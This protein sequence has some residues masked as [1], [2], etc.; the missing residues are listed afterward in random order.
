MQQ[1]WLR[2][3]F[4][5]RYGVERVIVARPVPP[6]FDVPAR[7]VRP[8]PVFVYPTLPRVFK[9]VELIGEAVR[10][11]EVSNRWRGSVLVTISGDENAY[12][13]LLHRRFGDLRSLRFIGRQT[14][15]QMDALYAGADALLFPSTLETWGMPLTEAQQ[16]G[17]AILA[18]DLPYARETVGAYARAAYVDPADAAALAAKML[19]LQEGRL[20]FETSPARAVEPPFAADWPSLVRLLLR[21]LA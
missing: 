12:A 19:A 1:S 6:A 16:H 3:E 13:R 14:R 15:A 5:A 2:D 7:A 17:L 18:A 8:A 9:N 4:R 20:Q 21:D 11:L 10:L